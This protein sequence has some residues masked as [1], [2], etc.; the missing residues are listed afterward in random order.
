MIKAEIT[1]NEG[2][3]YI[4]CLAEQ[5][6]DAEKAV[7]SALNEIRWGLPLNCTC[8]RAESSV[9]VLP[10]DGVFSGQIELQFRE[11]TV[12]HRRRQVVLEAASALMAAG[13]SD[14]WIREH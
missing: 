6:I 2:S 14:I 7:R 9:E 11:Q 4:C 10:V 5:A 8:F 3:I 12:P 13:Y 1:W